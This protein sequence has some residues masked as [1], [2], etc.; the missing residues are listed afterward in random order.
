MIPKIIH[1][2]WLSGEEMPETFRRYISGWRRLLPDYEFRLWDMKAMERCGSFFFR[3]AVKSG[4]YAFASDYVRLY[5]LYHAGG[6]YLDCDVE[7]LKRFDPLLTL[8]YFICREDTRHGIEAAVMGAEK[9]CGWIG[10]CLSYYDARKVV[11]GEVM[12]S[13]MR[14]IFEERG[15]RLRE[16]ASPGECGPVPGVVDI[17]PSSFFSPKSYVTN[18][19]CVVDDTYCIHHFSGSWQPWW[20]KMLL[21]VWVP[22]SYRCPRLAAKIKATG[23]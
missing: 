18:K 14:R 17:L 23:L 19:I 9:G 7:V 1:Y 8:P 6:I 13:V 3:E 12:P 15:W 4:K 10:E 11:T 20:K 2:C 22:F 21:K 16:I 5:A